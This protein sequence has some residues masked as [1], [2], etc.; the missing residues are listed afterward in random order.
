MN[1]FDALLQN[2]LSQARTIGIPVAPDIDPRVR[3]N[4]RA[5]GRFSCCFLQGGVHTIE[6]SARLLDAPERACRQTLAHEI[7]HT[8][9]DCRNHGPQWRSYA[10]RMN[11]AWGYSIARTISPSELGLPDVRPVRHMV[12]C[13]SCGKEFPRTRASRLTQHPEHFR[14]PCGGKLD[15]L[16]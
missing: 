7:L 1:D 15:L 13:L 11:T 16:F 6:L 5:V 8:C 10:A 12:I 14:C 4:R 2:V 9:P 3:V